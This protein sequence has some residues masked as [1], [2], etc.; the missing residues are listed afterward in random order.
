MNSTMKKALNE[1]SITNELRGASAFFSGAKTGRREKPAPP[2]EEPI[3]R[4]VNRSDNRSVY[5]SDSRSSNNV[6]L[7]T[8]PSRP[9]DNTLMEEMRT[10]VQSPV[11]STERY[12]FEIY[13]DQKKKL[14]RIRYVYEEKTGKKLSAS[15]ILREAIEPYLKELEERLLKP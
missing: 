13:S 14:N 3:D 8:T 9:P 1:S 6:P 4:T 2:P 10:G 15:R 7:R 5:R 12:A 11:R